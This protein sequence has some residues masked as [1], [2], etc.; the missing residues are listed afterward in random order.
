VKELRWR[1]RITRATSS[2]PMPPTTHLRCSRSVY[3]VPLIVHP[4]CAQLATIEPYLPTQNPR[5]SSA[6]YEMV[7]NHFLTTGDMSTFLR[8]MKKFEKVEIAP[9]VLVALGM[10]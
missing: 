4:I 2:H 10:A 8:L 3:V 1:L 7:L 5:L 9:V 6:T